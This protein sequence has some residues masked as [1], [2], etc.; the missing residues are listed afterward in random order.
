MYMLREINTFREEMGLKPIVV[1][2]IPCLSCRKS[3][4]SKDY[5]KQ[6]L[7]KKCRNNTD[8]FLSHEQDLIL[9]G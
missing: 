2:V 3:F 1:K 5:P 4:E 7:C 6:R 9:A 8:D